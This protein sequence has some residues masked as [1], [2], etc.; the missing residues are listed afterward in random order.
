MPVISQCVFAELKKLI[1][2]DEAQT[3]QWAM[4]AQAFSEMYGQP[5]A[6]NT[7]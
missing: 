5:V 1:D 7:Y 3:H 2:S 4:K 6:F